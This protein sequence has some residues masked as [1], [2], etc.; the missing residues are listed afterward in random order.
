VHLRA[1]STFAVARLRTFERR[2]AL[3][4]ATLSLNVPVYNGSA[5]CA[6]ALILPLLHTTAL[7]PSHRPHH[8]NAC[9]LSAQEPS[10]VA[11]GGAAG[12]ALRPGQGR[13]EP[14][15]Q[16]AAGVPRIRTAV[17]SLHVLSVIITDRCCM[18][19]VAAGVPR[20]QPIVSLRCLL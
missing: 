8:R 1:R 2:A 6:D 16:G 15:G 9:S 19:S 10:A 3:S 17:S 18:W 4:L 11:G 14:H 12:A 13:R 5:A 7:P 20:V